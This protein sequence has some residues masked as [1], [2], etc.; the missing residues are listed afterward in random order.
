MSSKKSLLSPSRLTLLAA[1]G[2]LSV[3]TLQMYRR[4]LETIAGVS[5][6]A[7]LLTGA[8]EGTCD[9]AGLP[10]HYYHA[11]QSGPPLVFVHGLGGSAE[12]WLFLF[13]RLSKQFQVYA[14]DLPG[15]GRTPLAPEGTNIRTH[16]LYLQRFLD[17]LNLFR[18]TLV[19]NSLGGWIA[20]RFVLDAPERIRHLYLLN[21]AGLSREGMFTPYTPD[22]AS[23]RRAISHWSGR[24]V[25]VPNFLLKAMVE[26]SRRPAY[27]GFIENYDKQE[28]LDDEL[29]QVRVPTTIIWGTEDRIL[30]LACAHDFHA[31]IP[32]SKLILLPGVGH[33]PQTG[34][35]SKV[36]NIISQDI[37]SSQVEM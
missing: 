24:P 2:G 37:A 16:A 19:G 20:T 1:A 8:R 18:V 22:F 36:V 11:G 31:S 9:A 34:A 25:R 32:G 10:I 21:S 30:P 13:P 27:S 33:T 4:P 29:A 26:S 35:V 23:A 3:F 12:N 15:F 14:L 7:M 5:R 28:E 17:A 6:T